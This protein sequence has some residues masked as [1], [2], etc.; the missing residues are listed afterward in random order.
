[1]AG[2]T[3]IGSSEFT[4]STLRGSF[5]I[6]DVVVGDAN[7]ANATVVATTATSLV[8]RSAG[9]FVLGEDILHNALSTTPQMSQIHHV[10]FLQLPPTNVT[11][12]PGAFLT[13]ATHKCHK[14][15]RCPSCHYYFSHCPGDND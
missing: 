10:F 9:N 12:A 4:I 1:M 6:G 8:V 3:I 2:D 15:I 13:T 11:N 5:E 7:A 14:S